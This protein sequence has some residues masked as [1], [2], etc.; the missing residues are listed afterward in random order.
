MDKPYLLMDVDGVILDWDAGLRDFIHANV[1]KLSGSNQIYSS[2]YDLSQR[3]GIS[4]ESA[5]S[6]VIEFHYDSSFERLNPLPGVAESIPRL[7]EKYQ[8]VAITACGALPDI[9]PARTKNLR[10]LFGPVFSSVYCVDNFND[11][12]QYLNQYPPSHWVEDH[13]SNAHLGLEY[14]HT[15]WLVSASHNQNSLLNPQI[16]RINGLKDLCEIIL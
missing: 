6:L 4:P 13:A 7:A 15:C 5:K 9:S 3:L 14:G 11:K 1:P 12:R 2:S 8:L 16:T 10:D